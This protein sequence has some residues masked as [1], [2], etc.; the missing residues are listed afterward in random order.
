MT[1]IAHGSYI[2]RIRHGCKQSFHVAYSRIFTL[3]VCFRAGPVVRSITIQFAVNLQSPIG[4]L[5]SVLLSAVE[6]QN[7]ATDNISVIEGEMATISCRVKNNDDSVI[8]LLNPNRQTIYFKDVRRKCRQ[9]RHGVE[10]VSCDLV[11]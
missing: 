6:G 11:K 7:L 1:N 9:L 2:K 8:Q 3:L 10:H 4:Y 5:I